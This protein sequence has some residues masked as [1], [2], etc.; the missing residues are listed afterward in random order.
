M[1]CLCKMCTLT[2]SPGYQAADDKAYY[3]NP[4]CTKKKPISEEAMRRKYQEMVSHGFRTGKR[5]FQSSW[6]N[7]LHGARFCPGYGGALQ[8]TKNSAKKHWSCNL[9]NVRFLPGKLTVKTLRHGKIRFSKRMQDKFSEPTFFSGGELLVVGS[10]RT[11]VQEEQKMN[12]L[13]R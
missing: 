4:S 3:F 6:C 10:I 11:S 12:C 9:Q 7:L 8:S 1:K 2:L 5:R 13:D